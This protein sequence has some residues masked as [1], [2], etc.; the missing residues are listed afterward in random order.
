MICLCVSVGKAGK[1][2]DLSLSIYVNA[3]LTLGMSVNYPS[4]D[5]QVSTPAE[6]TGYFGLSD[7]VCGVNVGFVGKH[8]DL[9]FRTGYSRVK[10]SR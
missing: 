8:F 9:H 6:F 7:L 5:C 3:P 10:T 2:V 1:Y 4:D